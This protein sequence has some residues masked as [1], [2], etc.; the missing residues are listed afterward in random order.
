MDKMTVSEH[1][2][3]VMQFSIHAVMWGREMFGDDEI[4][5][6]GTATLVCE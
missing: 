6:F 2:V 4:P 3:L 1:A 5:D